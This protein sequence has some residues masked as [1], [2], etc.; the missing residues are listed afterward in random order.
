MTDQAAPKTH[1][2]ANRQRKDIVLGEATDEARLIRFVAG[3]DGAVVPDLARKLPGRGIWV[4]AD[5]DSVA[6]AA[7]KGLFSRAAKT[8]LTVGPD[9]ADQVEALLARRVLEGLGLARKAG[10]IISGYE[11][12]V[13]ALATG[14]VAWLIEASDGAEDGRRKILAAARKAPTPPRLLGAFS[15]DE[16]GLALGG[17]NVIHTALLSGRGLDRWTLDVERLSGFRP[18]SPPDWTAREREEG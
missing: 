6:T 9:L 18:L 8:K 12:V 5:R 15:S 10:V 11:K 2:E 7:K 13:A 3:P 17:E 4:G 1:A 16:L 14:K